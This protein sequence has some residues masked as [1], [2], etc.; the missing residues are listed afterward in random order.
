[1][2]LDLLLTNSLHRPVSEHAFS[3]TAVL[4]LLFSS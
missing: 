2:P 3:I 4:W 1:M